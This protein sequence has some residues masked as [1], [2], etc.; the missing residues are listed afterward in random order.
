[1]SALE[2]ESYLATH[3]AVSLAQVVGI[4]DAKYGEVP[5]AF[6][7][8]KPGATLTES[9]AIAFCRGKIAP[10]KVP[11]YVRFVEEWPM[12]ATKIVK[13]RLKEALKDELAQA[14]AS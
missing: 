1:V 2:V 6:L 4:A 10:F 9:E 12:S 7:E 3:P 11:R 14:Q 5:A 8:L 13:F